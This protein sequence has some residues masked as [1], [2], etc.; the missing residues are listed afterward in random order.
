MGR[1]GG[2][3]PRQY[4]EGTEAPPHVS[5]R[6]H[7]YE[8][9]ELAPGGMDKSARDSALLRARCHKGLPADGNI[10][11]AIYRGRMQAAK[12][13]GSFAAISE[14]DDEHS[15]TNHA[16]SSTD[17]VGSKKR[18]APVHS[19]E[20][21]KL[22]RKHYRMTRDLWP[23]LAREKHETLA[24]RNSPQPQDI[25]ALVAEEVEMSRALRSGSPEEPPDFMVEEALSLESPRR[26]ESVDS[27]SPCSSRYRRPSFSSRSA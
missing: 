21:Q 13:A 1:P 20:D 3:W 10:F 25:D 7:S 6:P 27:A 14:S 5:V 12:A 24:G 4:E 23:K 9:R 19:Y 11:D 15:S 22:S 17:P 8:F 2:V 18:R 16:G 26:T